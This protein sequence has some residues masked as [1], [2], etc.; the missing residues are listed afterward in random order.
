MPSYASGSFFTFRFTE[1]RPLGL[2]GIRRQLAGGPWDLGSTRP[3]V[4]ETDLTPAV[5]CPCSNGILYQY[6]DRTDVTP[7]ISVNMG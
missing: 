1:D 5:L 6:P 7:L 2:W 3:P 4:P